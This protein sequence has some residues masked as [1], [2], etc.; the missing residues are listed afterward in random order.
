M[1]FRRMLHQPLGKIF[2]SILLGLGLASLFR[3]V[4]QDK[5][6]LEFRGP[7]VSAIQGKVFANGD[8]KCVEYG[9]QSMA[10]CPSKGDK[11]KVVDLVNESTFVP[12]QTLS[13][14]SES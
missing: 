12:N 5:Q 11:K 2:I 3:K 10:A 6:C 13:T 1:N 8:D 9:L 7:P 4:C 14:S